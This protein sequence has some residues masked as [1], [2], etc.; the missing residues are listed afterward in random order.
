MNY[1]SIIV[2]D[3][4]FNRNA[5][6]YD[7]WANSEREALGKL[8]DRKAGLI[9]GQVIRMSVNGM[10][11]HDTPFSDGVGVFKEP[12][13]LRVTVWFRDRQAGDY[14]VL[15]KSTSIA[16]L[17]EN[18]REEYKDKIKDLLIIEV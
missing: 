2:E 18:L 17:T 3:N 9:K 13:T 15:R 8:Y 6:F 10:I 1:Y 7:V 4:S 12:K 11:L 16:Q 5:Y 14:R